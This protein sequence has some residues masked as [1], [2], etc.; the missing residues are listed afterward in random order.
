[1]ARVAAEPVILKNPISPRIGL[2]V[3]ISVVIGFIK[4]VLEGKRARLG[5]F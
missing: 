5:D 1:M 2:N 4:M 3:L